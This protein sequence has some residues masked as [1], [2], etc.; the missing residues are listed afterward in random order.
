MSLSKLDEF[1]AVLQIFSDYNPK[2]TFQFKDFKYFTGYHVVSITESEREIPLFSIGINWWELGG[3]NIDQSDKEDTLYFVRV[4]LKAVHTSTS[5][6]NYFQLEQNVTRPEYYYYMDKWDA[7]LLRIDI[8]LNS[9]TIV[10]FEFVVHT[11]PEQI[12]IKEI[13]GDLETRSSKR[14]YS[15]AD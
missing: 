7:R 13:L 9:K 1:I 6:D 2:R 10:R 8:H 4:R 15:T 11:K 5:L 14:K 12:K 3:I